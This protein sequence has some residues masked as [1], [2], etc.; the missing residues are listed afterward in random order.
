MLISGLNTGAVNT[1]YSFRY[2][3]IIF[4]D[5]GVPHS[6]EMLGASSNVTV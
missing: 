6:Q 3:R 4:V 1:L 5:G 2:Y